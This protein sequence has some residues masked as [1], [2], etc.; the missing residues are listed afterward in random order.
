[1]HCK[2]CGN[3][4]KDVGRTFWTGGNLDEQKPFGEHEALNNLANNTQ[5]EDGGL[6]CEMLKV[7]NGQATCL[8]ELFLGY[9]AKPIYCQDHEGDDRCGSQ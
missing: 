2:R 9:D 5:G 1:M 4:C 6:P 8:I 3:C 7:F